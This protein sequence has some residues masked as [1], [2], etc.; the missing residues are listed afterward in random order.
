M[1]EVEVG[2]F[3]GALRRIFCELHLFRES[4]VALPR[5]VHHPLVH[6]SAD[7]TLP[8]IRAGGVRGEIVADLLDLAGYDLPGLALAGA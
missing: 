6:E 8:S 3:M 5:G 4:G 2:A 7:L 1:A